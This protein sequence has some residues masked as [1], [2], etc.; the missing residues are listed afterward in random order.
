[1]SE[2]GGLVFAKLKENAGAG[3]KYSEW[4]N[5]ESNATGIC[6]IIRLVHQERLLSRGQATIHFGSILVVPRCFVVK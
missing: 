2:G 1:M 6:W 3:V 5:I 4:S